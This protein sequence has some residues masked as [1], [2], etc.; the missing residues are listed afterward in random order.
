MKKV[1][2]SS[3]PACASRPVALSFTCLLGALASIPSLSATPLYWDLNGTADNTGTTAT[4]AWDETNAFWNTDSTGGAGGAAQAT[5][6]S[7]DDLFFSS[8]TG[9]TAGGTVTVTGA[10]SANSVTFEEGPITLSGGTSLTLGGGSGSSPGLVFASGTAANIISTPV[11]LGANSSFTQNSSTAQTIGAI[12]G[13]S[14]GKTLTVDGSGS[15]SVTVNGVIGTNVSGV[16]LNNA[17]SSLLLTAVNTYTGTTTLTTGTLRG[18]TTN[19][20]NVL[21]AFGTSAIALNGGTLQL[22]AN[23]SAN[24]QTIAVGNNVTIGGTAVTVDVNNNGANTGSN[25]TFGTLSLGTGQLNVTGGNSYLFRFSGATTLT[26]NATV[27]PTTGGLTL[28]GAIGDGGNGYSITKNGTGTLTLGSTNTYSGGTTINQGTVTLATTTA[29]LGT[30]AVAVNNT[31]TTGAGTAVVL[32]L[33][34]LSATTLGSLSGTISTPTSGTNTVTINNGGFNFSVNQTAVGTYQGLIAGTGGF[35]TSTTST[36]ALT[37]TGNNTYS[38]GTF[39][40]GGTLVAGVSDTSTTVSAFGGSSRAVNVGATSGS[41]SGSLLIGGAFTVGNN[42]TVRSGNTGTMTLGGSNTTGTATYT[43]NVLLG[44]A[45]GTAKSVTLV[46]A[47]GGTVDFSGVINE[48]TSGPASAVTVGN[49]SNFGTVKLSNAANAYGGVTTI[50]GGTLEVMKL[51]AGGSNSSIGNSGTSAGAG[52][53]ATDLVINGGTLKF[54]GT[55]GN[56]STN[57]LFTIG[58]NGATIDG[59]S[60]DNTAL[61]FTGT[62]SLATT[63]AATDRTLVLTGAT[64]AATLNSIA[65]VIVDPTGGGKTLLTKNGTNTWALGGTNTY[66]GATT[67]SAGTLAIGTGGSLAA[68]SAVTVES[69]GTLA[70]VGTIGGATVINGTHSAGTGGTGSQTFS[71]TL[72]YAS[73]SIFEWDLSATNGSDPGVSANQGTYDKVVAA[74]AIT[75]GSAIFKIVLGTNTFADAFWD[76]NKSWTDIFGGA[77][78][79]AALSALFSSFSATGGLASSGIAAGQG[80]FSFNGSTSTLNW[81]AV[82]EPTSALGGLL[83]VGGILHRRRVV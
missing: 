70:G 25:F 23:G 72:N 64:T 16:T 3:V 38:G 59:S 18:S 50:N 68:G 45:A 34:T 66:T 74:G 71:S 73:G 67:I 19:I 14:A 17:N 54:T 46:A 79:P 6:T 40:N 1:F 13:A 4:G 7:N 10:V 82:P 43:G 69:G 56:G 15:G 28:V 51:A 41:V 57:R 27:N 83:L 12:T 36:N 21:S 33:N 35:V 22:R 8:G 53:V 30:G 29:N 31:N 52:S 48:N 47:T 60:S 42:I 76:T 24:S 44:T 5:T 58:T 49:G 9:Y 81:I 32:N 39:V 55:T 80:Q 78:T 11:I 75:G 63:A 62:G 37:L 2:K 20:T 77:G 65:S 26:G 61:T